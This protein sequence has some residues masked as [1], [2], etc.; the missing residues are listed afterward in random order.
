MGVRQ[1]AFMEHL[2]DLVYIADSAE[3]PKNK[4]LR[5]PGIVWLVLKSYLCSTVL[6]LAHLSAKCTL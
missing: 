5:E 2:V 6:L 4:L 1:L 3:D